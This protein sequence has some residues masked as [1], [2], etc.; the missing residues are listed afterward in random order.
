MLSDGKS[1]EIDDPDFVGNNGDAEGDVVAI[2]TNTDVATKLKKDA[3]AVGHQKLGWSRGFL[4]RKR[5]GGNARRATGIS[6]HNSTDA[7]D[8]KAKVS[9]A[10]VDATH[11][12]A[13]EAPPLQSRR[14][15]GDRPGD[16]G[17][18]V[19]DSSEQS[20]S[21]PPQQAQQEAFTGSV[22]ERVPA[23]AP[24]MVTRAPGQ[25][26]VLLGPKKRLAAGGGQL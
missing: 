13:N 14:S 11:V 23:V 19:A 7:G 1:P 5:P 21:D 2:P 16:G 10:T 3:S 8:T 4:D 22:F 17:N 9:P 18:G 6:N 26:P 24:A 15:T 25:G 12:D 20:R